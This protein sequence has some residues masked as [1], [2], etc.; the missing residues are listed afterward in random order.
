V[1]SGI[2]VVL[3]VQLVTLRVVKREKISGQRRVEILFASFNNEHRHLRVLGQTAGYN[4]TSSATT[5]DD[6]VEGL[7]GAFGSCCWVHHVVWE[8]G[9]FL[10][11]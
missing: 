2:S 6:E 5:Y 8:Q 4:A 9:L 11:S 7:W 10:V 3:L 1:I